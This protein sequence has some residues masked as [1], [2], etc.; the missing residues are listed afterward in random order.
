MGDCKGEE[1]KRKRKEPHLEKKERKRIG[2]HMKEREKPKRG[3]RLGSVGRR[4][5]SMGEG[6]AMWA[7]RGKKAWLGLAWE[8]RAWLSG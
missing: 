4:L 3:R 1:M 6:L 2:T 7:R 5:G 8:E